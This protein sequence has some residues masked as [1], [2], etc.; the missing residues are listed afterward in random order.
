MVDWKEHG[1]GLYLDPTDPEHPK[2]DDQGRRLWISQARKWILATRHGET[3]EPPPWASTPALTRFTLSGPGTARWFS[4]YNDEQ[5]RDTQ[6]R[7]GSFGLIAHPVGLTSTIGGGAQPAAPYESDPQRWPHLEWYD[8]RTGKPVKVTTLSP[9]PDPEA[10]AHAL[11]RGDVRI[12]TLGDILAN[13]RHRPEHKSLAPNGAPC[14]QQTVGLLGRRPIESAPALTDLIGKEGNRLIERLTGEI[15]QPAD[16]RTD[17]G[18]RADR[19]QQLALPVL[20]EL[21]AAKVAE[22]TGKGRS[23]VFEA[24]SGRSHPAGQR[25]TPYR[26]AAVEHAAASLR[27]S[28]VQ[29]PRHPWGILYHYLRERGDRLVRRCAGCGQPIPPERR[30]DAIYCS[31]RCRAKAHQPVSR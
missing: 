9:H 26:D 29:V 10:F 11:S 3:V 19:W 24:I 31:D 14:D 21:G 5:P 27:T 6:I 13:Y 7:P 16:Y 15:T 25:Q 2:R 28:G 22:A 30:A 20:R 8:R 18:V 23:A 1:L 17:Y 4:G 12:S